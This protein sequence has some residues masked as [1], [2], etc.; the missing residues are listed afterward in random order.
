[1]YM[2]RAEY[3]QCGESKSGMGNQVFKLVVVDDKLP[4]KTKKPKKPVKKK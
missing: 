3:S 2:I 4:E 1:M